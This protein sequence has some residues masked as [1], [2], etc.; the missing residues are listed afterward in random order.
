MDSIAPR[1]RGN[2]ADPV[3]I[4][5]F[6]NALMDGKTYAEAVKEAGCSATTQSG[7]SMAVAKFMAQPYFKECIKE[8]KE[9]RK[10]LMD[11]L[12]AQAVVR[13]SKDIQHP[14]WRCAHS[15][16]SEA[17]KFIVGDEK[18]QRIDPEKPNSAQSFLEALAASV[19][20]KGVKST[21]SISMEP[22][23]QIIDAVD[24]EAD[25][26]DPTNHSPN[27]PNAP[28]DAPL[29]APLDTDSEAPTPPPNGDE[30]SNLP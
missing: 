30:G 24:V 1:R 23:R 11:V 26:Q 5:L 8:I 2:S 13:L 18:V 29:N 27:P 12:V 22:D 20:A 6:A 16:I 14:D 19:Q 28:L 17:R 7:I 9:Q 15:A 21:V 10:P 3:S 25:A 4:S